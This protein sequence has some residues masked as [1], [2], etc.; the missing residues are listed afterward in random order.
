MLSNFVPFSRTSGCRVS[1]ALTYCN[2]RMVV[3]ENDFMRVC[4]LPEKGAEIYQLEYKTAGV[5]VLFKRGQLRFPA[6]FTAAQVDNPTGFVDAYAGG[7]QELFPSGGA[8]CRVNGAQIGTHG[9]S[10]LLP[11]NWEILEDREERVSVRFSLRLLRFPFKLTRIMTLEK[12]RKVLELHE[13]V[14]NTG[15]EPLSFMWGHHPAFG[16]PFLDET[17]VLDLPQGNLHV[18]EGEPGSNQRIMPGSKGEWPAISGRYGNFLDL[19]NIPSQHSRH[20]GYV[21]PGRV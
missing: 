12:K 11:W 20:I 2:F 3:L 8:A 19:R 21:L 1:D 7:W 5:D 14:E 4:V 6:P 17:C 18:H 13:C 10:F 15:M 16:A 9:E